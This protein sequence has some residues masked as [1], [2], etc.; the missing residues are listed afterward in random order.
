MSAPSSDNQLAVAIL[1]PLRVTNAGGSVA[2]GGRQQRAILARLTVA[3]AGG[4]SLEQ[5]A[6]ML[7]GERP[8]GG[9]ATTIQTYIS[10]LRKLLEPNQTAALPAASSSPTTVAIA[11]PCHPRPSTSPHFRHTV[12]AGR[13]TARRRRTGRSRHET[14]ATLSPCGAATYSKTSPTTSSWHR[15]R[16]A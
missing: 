16:R 13:A 3:G 10:H 2:L 11:W 9:Y 7:W 5:F 4:V 6:D 12:E 1:G 14:S 15:S 8:P